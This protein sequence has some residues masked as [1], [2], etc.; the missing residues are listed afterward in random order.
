MKKVFLYT[1]VSTQEQISGGGFARQ[2]EVCQKFCEARGWEVLRIFEESVSGSDAFQDRPK[3]LEAL[4]LAG[5]G[6]AEAIVVERAD[7]LARDLVISELFLREARN[8]RVEVYASDYGDEL[9]NAGGDETRVLIR[10]ILSAL[11]QFDKS[12]IVKKL[13]AGRRRKKQE[14]G[15]PCGGPKTYGHRPEEW[16]GIQTILR[17]HRSGTTSHQDIAVVMS[18]LT[19]GNPRQYPKPQMK[20]TKKKSRFPSWTWHSFSITR[21]VEYWDPRVN[22]ALDRPIDKTK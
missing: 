6:V 5:Q 7:R 21:I 12:Q 15:A 9:V 4:T 16:Y 3:L 22:A 14:T 17:M 19:R 11:A 13:Q 18:D 10:Q 20:R 1:R 2:Q 8:L